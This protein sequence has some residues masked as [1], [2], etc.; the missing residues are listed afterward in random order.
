MLSIGKKFFEAKP[1]TRTNASLFEPTKDD[2]FHNKQTTTL[3]LE[4]KREYPQPH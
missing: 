1:L 4:D 3:T 2:L